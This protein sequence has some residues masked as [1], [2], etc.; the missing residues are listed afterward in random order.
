MPEPELES[1]PLV[2]D[3]HTAVAVTSLLCLV[4]PTLAVLILDG[5]EATR[6][7]RAWWFA[8]SAVG[9]AAVA[10][11]YW[12]P[13]RALG[14]VPVAATAWVAATA[15]GVY[16][17]E[18]PGRAH[19]TALGVMVG[20]L[21]RGRRGAAPAG[22]AAVLGCAVAL[23]AGL[24]WAVVERGRPFDGAE[25]VVLGA[26]AALVGVAWARL[27]RPA[28]ELALEPV[29]WAAYRIRWAGPG[30]TRFPPTGPC[31]ILAN[32]GCWFDPIFL[33]KVFPRPITPMMTSRF[34]DLPVI[35][36]LVTAFGVIRVPEKALKKDAP[37]V[38][39]AIAALDRGECVV[40]F[41]EGYLRRTA[42]RPL[43]RFGQGVWQVLKARP[44]TPVYATWIE[45][46][47][48]SFTSYFNGPPTKNKK[49]DFRRPV[50]VGVSAPVAVPSAELEDHL[51]TRIHLMNL[52]GEA[53]KHI[54]LPPL[55]PFALP[56]AADGGE[57]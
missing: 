44:S 31:L 18:W 46:G 57:E 32:H 14:L 48:G 19:G 50:G 52:V 2:R 21:V 28:F 56:S 51:R 17:G 45:G 22:E 30:L 5:D 43:R 37:E 15:H 34:Y 4:I 29:L 20:A 27:F 38:R 3:R 11:L 54:G 23:G 49:K 41:P 35:R 39:E 9:G 53:R 24:A 8:G 1:P 13:Y 6:R 42:D 26:A 10:L 7:A 47:W 25:W 36:R 33:A 16:W 40:I 12:S 55:P